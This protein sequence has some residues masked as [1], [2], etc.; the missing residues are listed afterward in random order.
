[1]SSRHSL[2]SNSPMLRRLRRF[3]P[4]LVIV[5]LTALALTPGMVS[6]DRSFEISLCADHRDSGDACAL[7]RRAALVERTLVR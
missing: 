4:L 2:A 3:A 1:M 6:G 5:A 7:L